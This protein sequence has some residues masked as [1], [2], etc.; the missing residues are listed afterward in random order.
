MLKSEIFLVGFYGKSGISPTL[1]KIRH[2]EKVRIM[3]VGIP[4]IALN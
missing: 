4:E 1:P 2:R 3:S